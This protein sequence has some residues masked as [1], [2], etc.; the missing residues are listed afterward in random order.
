MI[1][2]VAVAPALL[3]GL[4]LARRRGSPASLGLDGALV[5]L[6]GAWLGS[7]VFFAFQWYFTDP[8]YTEQSLAGLLL[9]GGQASMGG[10]AGMLPALYLFFHLSGRVAYP[11]LAGLL[12]EGGQASMGGLAGMLPALY[13]FFHLSGRVAYPL[14]AMDVTTPPLSLYQ[15][16]ARLGCFAAGCCHGTPSLN[17]PWAVT[18][19][20]PRAA[21][22]YLGTPLHPAQ[23]YLSVGSLALSAALVG[24]ALR[25]AVLRGWLLAVYLIGY[26]GLRFSVEFVRGDH[27]PFL[28]L[29]SLNQWI[30]LGFLV[31]GL[32]LA[33]VRYR[34]PPR[35]P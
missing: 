31:S 6:A 32:L 5:A 8:A 15:G 20:D 30:C 35:T 28:G 10:L 27:R 4:S 25:P 19:T 33:F 2:V 13:L 11:E 18:F 22:P 21:C 7:R 12:L 23:I 16:L 3:L 34:N 9:E 26:G 17:L 14:G 24:L 29:L 1:Y